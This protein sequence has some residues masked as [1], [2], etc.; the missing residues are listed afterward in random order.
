M[1]LSHYG[2]LKSTA[3]S[4]ELDVKHSYTYASTGNPLQ[5]ILK[6]PSPLY[7][8][9]TLKPK[10]TSRI[11]TSDEFIKEMEEKEIKKA[12]DAHLKEERK[13]IR[14]LEKQSKSS[15]KHLYIL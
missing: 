15:G 8:L 11:L 14:E 3:P 4:T 7:H 5:D 2:N 10:T 1:S 13:F 9:P 6:Y 12:Q